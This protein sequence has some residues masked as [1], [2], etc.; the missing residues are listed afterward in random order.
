MQNSVVNITIN[1]TLRYTFY[2]SVCE[3]FNSLFYVS[4]MN[5]SFVFLFD[6][7]EISNF[8]VVFFHAIDI[9]FEYYQ[10][11]SSGNKHLYSFMSLDANKDEGERYL[12]SRTKRKDK[13]KQE[14][15]LTRL[16][17]LSNPI[18]NLRINHTTNQTNI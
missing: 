12:C 6:R 13:D 8:H 15:D 16:E 3:D 7:F 5:F 17:I 14:H 11:F 18:Q 10:D 4:D 1:H 2:W 9:V